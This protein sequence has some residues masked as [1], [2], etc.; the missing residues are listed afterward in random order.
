MLYEPVFV[1]PNDLVVSGGR[2][3][4][5]ERP[6]HLPTNIAERPRLVKPQARQPSECKTLVRLPTGQGVA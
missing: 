3:L 6:R 4:G 2:P 5:H 1:P